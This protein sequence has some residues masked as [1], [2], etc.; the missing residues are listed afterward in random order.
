MKRRDVL[1]GHT[2]RIGRRDLGVAHH[3]GFH[4]YATT[5]GCEC[6]WEVPDLAMAPTNGGR[7]AATCLHQGHVEDLL[8]RDPELT[9]LHARSGWRDWR[10]GSNPAPQRTPIYGGLAYRV[11]I[12][13]IE[14]GLADGDKILLVNIG[15]RTW[16]FQ[17]PVTDERKAA[18]KRNA[19]YYV[20]LN[21][22]VPER[23]WADVA[24]LLRVLGAI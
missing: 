7:R 16:A 14:G 4:A 17:F 9:L 13:R 2:E 11:K 8:S 24:P 15:A 1:A 23:V 21:R 5:V 20:P 12:C 18:A 6:G 19:D 22:G 10:P 3:G